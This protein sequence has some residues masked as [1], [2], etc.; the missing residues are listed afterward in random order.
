MVRILILSRDK[1]LIRKLELELSCKA[2]TVTDADSCDMIIYDCE[3][4]IPMPDFHGRVLTLSR[5][6]AEGAEP[7]PFPSGNIAQLVFSDPGKYLT[8]LSDERAATF[9][10]KRIKLTSHEYSLLGLLLS[11]DGYV[12]REQIAK[13]VW[14][15]A[16]DGL[17][18][19]YIHYLREKLEADGDKVIISSRKYG[20]KINEKY[21]EVGVC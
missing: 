14:Q 10:S 12:S 13:G 9:G 6:G 18:N 8:L 7:I 11:S 19:I 15:D 21:K 1:Y 3:S 4:G 20:Y 16:A 5:T 17:I 2:D